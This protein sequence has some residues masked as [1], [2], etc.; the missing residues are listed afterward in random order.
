MPRTLPPPYRVARQTQQADPT[1]WEN[2]LG[3]A[4]EA[5]FAAGLW[6]LPA[7]VESV[8]QRG[9]TDRE[10]RPWTIETFRAELDRLGR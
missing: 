3:D 2:R 5:A 9:L 10:G 1:E 6:E 8:T 7:L 4:I